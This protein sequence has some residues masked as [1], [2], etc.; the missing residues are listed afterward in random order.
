MVVLVGL[1]ITTGAIS[2]AAMWAWIRSEEW[3]NPTVGLWPIAMTVL[4]PVLWLLLGGWMTPRLTSVAGKEMAAL[5]ELDP[6]VVVTLW[7]WNGGCC[8][9]R[10]Q[11]HVD[12][13]EHPLL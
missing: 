9:A 5:R 13:Y 8:A 11:R 7:R 1:I 12:G 3:V 4:Q 10:R 6:S 2:V